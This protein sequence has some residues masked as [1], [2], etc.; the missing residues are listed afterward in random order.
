MKNF[1]AYNELRINTHKY[2]IDLIVTN[3]KIHPSEILDVK[4]RTH[5]RGERLMSTM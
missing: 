2:S 1:C 4:P 5:L 3:R